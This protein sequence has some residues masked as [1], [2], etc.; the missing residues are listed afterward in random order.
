VVYGG[1][2]RLSAGRSAAHGTQQLAFW[3]AHHDERD[4]KEPRSRRTDTNR[5]LLALRQFLELRSAA[6][7][8]FGFHLFRR[9]RFVI[10]LQHSSKKT[11]EELVWSSPQR[12]G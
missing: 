6:L 11:D 8:T 2:L 12:A 4:S 9:G 5:C 1:V 10:A 7:A 3:N